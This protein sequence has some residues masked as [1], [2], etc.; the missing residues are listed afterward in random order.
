MIVLYVTQFLFHPPATRATTAFTI[1]YSEA[2]QNG[3]HKIFTH[4]TPDL[5]EFDYDNA[6]KSV[7][8]T[9]M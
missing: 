3:P 7:H 9:G 2:A 8:Q 4:Y 5:S 6:I 1:A